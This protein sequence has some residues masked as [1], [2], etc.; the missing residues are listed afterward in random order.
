M[1]Q[2]T[3]ELALSASHPSEVLDRDGRTTDIE[4]IAV[5][6]MRRSYWGSI[7]RPAERRVAMRIVK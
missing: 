5:R 1:F 7:R 2:S 4:R 6:R 3:G